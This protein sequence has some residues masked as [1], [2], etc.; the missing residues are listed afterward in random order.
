MAIR[1][2]RVYT[3]AGDQGDTSLVGGER[4]SKASPRVD[5][6]GAVDELNAA[7]GLVHK[8]LAGPFEAP[9]NG[10]V[11]CKTTSPT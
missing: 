3:K 7:I 5:C 6:Y 4:V 11:V 9:L 2:N 10:S 8:K 1:I